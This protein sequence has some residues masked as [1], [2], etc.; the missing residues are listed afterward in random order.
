MMGGRIWVESE[1]GKGS[2]FFFTATFSRGRNESK[3]WDGNGRKPANLR[4][5]VVDDSLPAREIH[6]DLVASLGY[7]ALLAESAEAGIGILQTAANEGRPIEVVLMDWRMPGLDGFEATERIRNL[8]ALEQHQPKILMVTAYGN[9]A[10]CLGR[11]RAPLDGVLAKPLTPSSLLDAVM[12]AFGATG[13]HAVAAEASTRLQDGDLARLR[14]AQVLLVE[15]ND[16]NQQVAMELLEMVGVQVTLAGDGQ[17]ALEIL[18]ARS[19][20]AVLMDLQMPVL[21]GYDATRLIRSAPQ[22]HALPIIAMTAHALVHERDRCLALGMNDY[23]SKPVDPDQLYAVLARWIRPE[24]KVADH[25][26]STP[27]AQEPKPGAL[28]S[29]L[30]GI[31][32]EDGLAALNGR[33]DRYLKMLTKFLQMKAGTTQEIR[34]TLANGDL[35]A[36]GRAAHSMISGAG[37]I[38]AMVLAAAALD[39][40]N[41]IIQREEPA[42]T[43]ALERFDLAL[44]EVLDGLRSRL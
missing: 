3:R 14:G 32:I 17:A 19:F 37:T 6:R 28:P 26:T 42:L 39:L 34:T 20:D 4:I 16:F 2:E 22:F 27:T 25:A 31:S 13:N 33:E 43:T 15:D 12:N 7:E 30:P 24:A 38:G 41:A 21:D 29:H 23:V 40:Q 36:A 11:E 44:T 10:T 18:H 8:A 35:E 1:S 5:L 9:E